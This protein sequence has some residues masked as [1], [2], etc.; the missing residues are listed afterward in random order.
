MKKKKIFKITGISIVSLLLL[1]FLAL[2]IIYYT[3]VGKYSEDLKKYPKY[4]GFIDEKTSLLNDMKLCGEKKILGK[5]HGL[6][7]YAFYKNKGYF[8]KNILSKYNSKKFSDSGYLNFRFLINCEGKA[9]WFKITK[10]N[11]DLEETNLNDEMV[12]EL[13][14]LTSN[15]ENW[16]ELSFE[17][18]KKYN[19]HM[20]ILYRIENGKIVEI[21]P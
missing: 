4:I 18:E 8:R 9:G 13:L 7:K 2:S 15:S 5:H 14:E 3:K 20:Y 10:M 12:N 16:N 1:I 21:L 17:N 6:P 11:L 19:Y